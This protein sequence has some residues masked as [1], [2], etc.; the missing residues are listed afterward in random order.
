[1]KHL[2]KL[3]LFLPFFI[4]ANEVGGDKEV[5]L[6]QKERSIILISAFTANG[7]LE[8][9]NGAFKEGLD[10]GLTINEINEVIVHLYAYVGFPK[11]LNALNSFMQ[12][13]KER[14]K[15]GIVDPQGKEATPLPKNFDKD[16]YGAKVRAQLAGL[17]K[18]IQ[19]APWQE[20]SPIIDTFLKE[21]LFADIFS[22]DILDFK[23]R[24]LVTVAA[25]AAMQGTSGQLKFH[26]GAAMNVGATAEQLIELISLIDTK[27]DQQQAKIARQVL[28]ETL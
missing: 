23:T 4:L 18:D 22:R 7:D 5:H 11:S 28:S 24:E 21:H 10:A 8:K 9:L 3:F 26:L 15:A 20:F 27:V 17:E 2:L 6:N 1:M 19:G 13:I 12:Q 16:A 25:L 14:K